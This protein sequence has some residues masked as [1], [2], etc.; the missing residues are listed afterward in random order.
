L[1]LFVLAGLSVIIAVVA[2]GFASNGP[3]AV[4]PRALVYGIVNVCFAVVNVILG[5]AL[6]VG[7]RGPRSR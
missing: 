6:V 4:R 2:L 5:L 1:V 3:A 7:S